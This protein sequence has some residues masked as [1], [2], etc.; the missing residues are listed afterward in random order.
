MK[1]QVTHFL[2]GVF[3]T[4]LFIH[5]Y[6]RRDAPSYK[7]NLVTGI[8]ILVIWIGYVCYKEGESNGPS[9]PH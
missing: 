1:S 7:W 9:I 2:T 6:Q 8:I 3:V 4:V 5:A